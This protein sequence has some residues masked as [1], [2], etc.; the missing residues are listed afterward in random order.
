M[1]KHLNKTTKVLIKSS[2]EIIHGNVIEFKSLH[3]FY[4]KENIHLS[5]YLKKVKYKI[6]I[7]QTNS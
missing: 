6:V 5:I 3:I 4:E 2:A 7:P 1:G